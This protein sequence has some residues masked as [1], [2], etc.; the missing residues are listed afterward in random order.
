MLQS[1]LSAKC[2]REEKDGVVVNY[3]RVKQY[4]AHLEDVV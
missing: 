2:K 1:L 4:V 3:K